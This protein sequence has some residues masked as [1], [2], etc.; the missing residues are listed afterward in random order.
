MFERFEHR[1]LTDTGS[2][3]EHERVVDLLSRPLPSMRE[4]FNQV[5]RIVRVDVPYEVQP[6]LG[7][8]RVAALEWQR[9]PIEIEAIDTFL[10]STVLENNVL[11]AR[12][13]LQHEVTN[14]CA[15]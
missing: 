4:V 12:L 10:S 3:A 9:R 1:V 5:F 2:T 8:F 11:Y 7:L 14:E 15:C 13:H 6:R